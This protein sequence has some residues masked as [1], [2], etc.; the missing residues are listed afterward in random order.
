MKFLPL[1]LSTFSTMITENYIYVDKTKH[2]YDL[3]SRGQRLYFLARPRRFGKSLLISTLKELFSGNRNLF[4]GLWIDSSD[5]QWQQYPIIHLD[6]ANIGHATPED[7]KENLSWRLQKI[8]QE[9]NIDISKDP[10]VQ[11]QIAS[12]IIALGKT[13]NKVVI[14]ID[15]Y[16][17]P[18]LDHISNL[19]KAEQMKKIIAGLYETI[20]SMD[21]HM[22]AIFVTG[23]TKFAKTSIFSG[24]NN[25]NDISFEPEAA[26]LLGYTQQ[27]IIHYFSNYIDGITEK[28]SISRD[29]VFEN[30]KEWYNGYRFSELAIKVYNPF[31]ITYYLARK[32]LANYWFKSGTPTFLIH[33]IK[34]QFID[35]EKIPTAALKS[36]SLETFELNNIPLI[37]LLFQAGYLTIDTYDTEN[38]K[39][40]LNYPN[41]EIEESFTKHIIISLTDANQTTVETA[42]DTLITSLKKHD[43]DTFCKVLQSLFGCIPYTLRI[44]QENY[45]HS[46]FQFL[47]SL[48]ILEIHSE[49]LTNRGRIDSVLEIDDYIYIFELK[50]NKPVQEALQQIF[51]RKYYEK[52]LLYNK[53]IILVGLSFSTVDRC[54][55]TYQSHNIIA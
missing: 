25:L 3:F 38:D 21:A 33:L 36:S 17:K 6:F 14:L 41:Y 39:V 44:D 54:V 31:S 13:Y 43:L 48:L 50:I 53:K 47:I 51:D 15:E 45:Y 27:E 46:L 42:L 9:Y 55:V 24:M 49:V 8:A 16:D 35:L 18:I 12:L 19:E 26:Q 29:M 23:V 7:L 5:Y 1:D 28:K 32:K 4:K 20:K 52:Y 11:A 37:P 2:I 34:H 22:R 10:S 40:T 30:M